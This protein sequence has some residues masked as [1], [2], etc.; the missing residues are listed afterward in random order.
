M[1]MATINHMT[2]KGL[3]FKRKDYQSDITDYRQVAVTQQ[4][5]LC[6]RDLSMALQIAQ[7]N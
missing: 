4:F 5:T 1:L 2:E 7:S 6:G 3:P